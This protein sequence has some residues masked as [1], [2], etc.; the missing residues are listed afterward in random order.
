MATTT[1]PG[2]SEPRV[3]F[4]TYAEPLSGLRVSWGSVLAGAVAALAVALILWALALAI[5][6]TATSSTPASIKGSFI[7]LWIC[8]MVTTLAGALVGGLLAGYL[9]GNPSRMIGAVHGFL[10]WALAFLIAFAIQLTVIGALTRAT[11]EAAMTT[12][13]IAAET[14]GAAV[15]GLAGGQMA[16]DRKAYD[17]LRSLGFSDAESKQMVSSARSHLQESLRSGAPPMGRP[18][19]EA[20]SAAPPSGADI[21]HAMN[22]SIGWI[23]GLSWSWFGTW[24]ISA[25]LAI[26]GGHFAGKRLSQRPGGAIADE[27]FAPAPPA[28]PSA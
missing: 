14:A 16:L 26:V 11:T 27:A 23:A 18:S 6:M 15:G 8:A 10:A 22:V 21:T 24:F 2:E 7:A 25:A 13:G 4:H 12:A 17:L 28:A 5:T 19:R 3:A 1:F 20:P 9:P